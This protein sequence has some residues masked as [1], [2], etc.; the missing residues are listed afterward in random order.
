MKLTLPL[1]ALAVASV[2]GISLRADSKPNFTGTWKL[3]V[4][5]SELGGRPITELTVVVEH[6]DPSFR[7]TSS[8]VADGNSFDQTEE[9]TTDNKPVQS[10]NGTIA[11]AHWEGPVL[12]VEVKSVE[13]DVLETG[14][15]SMSED[16][17]TIVREGVHNGP[18]GEQKMREI[19]EKQ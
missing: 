2:G 5:K 17:K 7:F 19:Y 4:A 10:E 6:K 3:N 13:G 11:T 12:V 15:L 18:D 14:R 8:G 16:G 9:L 1:L